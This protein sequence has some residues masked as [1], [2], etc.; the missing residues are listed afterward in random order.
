MG[1]LQRQGRRER[2]GGRAGVLAGQASANRAT[3]YPTL[4]ALAIFL[5]TH[6]LSA[7]AA[8]LVSNACD[9]GESARNGQGRGCGSVF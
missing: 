3:W 7:A 2:G 6:G 9:R 5:Q 1:V 4:K 8:I